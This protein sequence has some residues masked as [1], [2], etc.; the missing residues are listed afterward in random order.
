MSATPLTP[1][2]GVAVE[3]LVAAGRIRRVP[4]DDRRAA[5]FLAIADERLAELAGIRSDV[6]R[7]G[8]AY[9]AA[10]DVGEAVLAAYGYGTVNGP[11]Q[12]AAV[13]DFL[14]ALVDAPPAAVAA[15]VQ[16]DRIRRARNQQNYRG[17]A[18]GAGTAASVEA[19][20]RALRMVADDR[21]I[22]T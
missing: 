8:V 7:L 20:A 4:V 12:H 19:V 22:G 15:A 14:V 18:V 2:Q 10:P 9:D 13:G 6:V 1:M 21:R 16:F 5:D 3:A 17:A 11:G